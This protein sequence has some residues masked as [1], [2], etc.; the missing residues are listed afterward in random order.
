MRSTI[1]PFAAELSVTSW[2]EYSGVLSYICHRFRRVTLEHAG[3]PVRFGFR[4]ADQTSI[5]ALHTCIRFRRAT[6]SAR[7]RP[8][9]PDGTGK[10]EAKPLP[11]VLP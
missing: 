5:N 4:S 9:Q 7:H 10:A 8:M 2:V 11:R 1:D 6:I 3:V